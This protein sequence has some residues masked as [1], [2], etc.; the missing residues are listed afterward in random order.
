MNARNEAIIQARA[1]GRPYQS[2]AL[3]HGLSVARVCKIVQDHQKDLR[4]A[5][6]EARVAHLESQQVLERQF[7][8]QVYGVKLTSDRH[9]A[10]FLLQMG[11]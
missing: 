1:A 4:I 7:I 5:E 8:E 3:E 11:R 10:E 2:I 6:L 9:A